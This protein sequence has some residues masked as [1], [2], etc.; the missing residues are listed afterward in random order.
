MWISWEMHELVFNIFYFYYI[1]INIHMF[2]KVIAYVYLPFINISKIVEK[3]LWIRF[4]YMCST[5]VN[6]FGLLWNLY[7]L[8]IFPIECL[9]LK[10]LCLTFIALLQENTKEYQSIF[11]YIVIIRLLLFSTKIVACDDYFPPCPYI[12]LTHHM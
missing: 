1:Y 9:T 10:M 2:I 8:L 6:M 7:I 3:C 5:L 11:W 12:L 4:V